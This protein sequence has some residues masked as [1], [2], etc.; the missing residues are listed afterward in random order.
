MRREYN[1]NA[2]RPSAL[3]SAICE[4]MKKFRIFISTPLESEY[5][6]RIRSVAPDRV[7]VLFDP[8]LMPEPLFVGDHTGDS[9][10]RRTRQMEQRWRDLATSADIFWDIPP[11]SEDGSNVTHIADRLSW[12]QTTSSGIG[13]SVIKLGLMDSD[14][15]I[16]NARGVHAGPLSEFAF[17]AMLLHS[18]GY[19]HLKQEQARHR[20]QYECSD[21]LAGRTL[22]IIGMGEIGRRIASLGKQFGMRV[23]ALLRDGSTKTAADLEIEQV[24]EQHELHA[25]LSRTDVLVLCAPHTF[26]TAGM[27]DRAA[28]DAM[29]PGGVLVNI[30]RGSLVDE[31]AMVEAL[32]S[33]HLGFAALDV[34]AR[35]PLPTDSPL[36]D[37]ENVLVSP[38]SAST[39]LLE[40]ARITDIFCYNLPLFLEGRYPEM[41]NLFNRRRGY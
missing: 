10:F 35:E 1:G 2:S 37:L 19:A 4:R 34:F 32:R 30:A 25:M 41:K 33:R 26:D 3:C 36:W 29:K 40:N 24:F 9:G 16:T 39:I 20:W 11:N 23:I 28:F 38:H 5:V 31:D 15:V 14:I 8:N 17:M 27:L 22:A 6:D 13:P 18:R 7:D 21:S 12:I